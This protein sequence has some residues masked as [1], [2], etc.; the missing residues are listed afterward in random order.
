MIMEGSVYDK[1]LY[2]RISNEIRNESIS[3]ESGTDV[4]VDLIE[5][6]F[7]MGFS[8]IDWEA[9]GSLVYQD[10]GHLSDAEKNTQIQTTLDNLTNSNSSIKDEPIVV[11]GDGAIDKVYRMRFGTFV[12]IWRHFFNLPQHTYVYFLRTH[13]CM[14]YTFRD[15]LYYG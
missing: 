3:I 7:P 14:N 6:H 2:E 11:I 13:R 1:E 15:E 4:V 12:S 9:K 5:R 10:F 8:G